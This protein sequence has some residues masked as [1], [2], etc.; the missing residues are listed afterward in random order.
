MI[1]DSGVYKKETLI[2]G[3]P[4]LIDCIAVAG[5]VFRLSGKLVTT[6]TLED[7]WYEDLEDPDEA[8]SIFK[9]MDSGKG[10]PDIV[11]FW[12]RYPY[13]EPRYSYRLEREDI[14]ILPIKS[15]DHWLRS[16]IKS[17]VRSQIHKSQREGLIVRETVY[18]DEFVRGMTQIFNEAPVRQG[19]KFWH[20]GKTHEVVKE[21][22]SR[23]LDREIMIGAYWKDELIG[24]MMLGNAGR[25]ALTGQI[26]SSLAHRD[27][28]TNNAMIAKAVQVCEERGLPALCYLFW[29]E[30]SLSE[31]KRRCGF[32]RVAMPRFYVPIT[33]RGER[34]LT[35]G[36]HKGW[37]DLVPPSAKERLKG[38][39]RSW[40]SRRP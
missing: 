17:R 34:C 35:L 10:K 6:A 1:P 4:S 38:W 11:T 40:Y 2:K 24:F 15:H 14:A 7:E 31:F 12:Q 27:K 9:G 39:R 20:Y 3:V 25:F 8:I 18:D 21:Q 37:R 13:I 5:Q 36:C 22:F 16:Q 19:R 28:A 23:Y 33:K 29:S 32:E 26:I 30:D